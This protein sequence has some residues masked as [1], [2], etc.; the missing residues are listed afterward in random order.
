[1]IPSP[2]PLPFPGAYLLH[3]GQGDLQLLAGLLQA[4]YDLNGDMLPALRRRL[5]DFFS[6]ETA[7]PLLDCSWM[8]FADG[9][10]V[11][12]CLVALSNG[13]DTPQIVDLVTARS[14]QGHG[15]ATVLMQKTFHTLVERGFFSVRMICS[16]RAASLNHKLQ[17]L[18]FVTVDA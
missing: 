14:W 16:D 10:P 4:A 3:P 18:G 11:S 15:L 1:M 6:R 2:L 13:S 7:H 12:A 8:C 9:V 5:R 17:S